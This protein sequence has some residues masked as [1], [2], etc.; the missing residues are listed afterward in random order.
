VV[1]DEASMPAQ[2]RVG[3]DEE[4]R[5]AVTAEHTRERSEDRSVV[6]FEARPRNLAV[7]HG[8]LMAQHEDFDILGTLTAAMQ[9]QQVDHKSDDTVETSHAS[10]LAALEPR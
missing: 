2:D 8:E 10:M 9:H 3:S 1:R 7:Q 6:G 5:P 4:D